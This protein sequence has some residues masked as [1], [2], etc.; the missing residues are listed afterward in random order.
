MSPK[1]AAGQ[2]LAPVLR[3]APPGE[4]KVYA[5]YEHQLDVLAQGSPAPLMLNF[6]LFFL[7]V[8]ASAFGTLYSAPPTADRIYYIFFIIFILCLMAGVVLAALWALMRTPVMSL[9]KEIKSQMPPNP[10]AQEGEAS[11]DRPDA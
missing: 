8:A 11:A 1:K 9:I 7:G 4:L 5:V 2:P 10:V 6:A 3:Y